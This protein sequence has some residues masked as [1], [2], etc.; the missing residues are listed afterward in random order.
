V[1]Q[2]VPGTPVERAGMEQGDLMTAVDGTRVHERSGVGV[3]EERADTNP[4]TVRR[5]EALLDIRV[6]LEVL[7]PRGSAPSAG[8]PALLAGFQPA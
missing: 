2:V 5:D 4:L 1:L 3:S 8:R 7:A 6:E